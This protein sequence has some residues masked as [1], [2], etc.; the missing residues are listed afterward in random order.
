MGYTGFPA[1]GRMLDLPLL[2]GGQ[3]I[4]TLGPSIVVTPKLAEINLGGRVISA[5]LHESLR[6]SDYIIL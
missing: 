5:L 6:G 3:R 2:A 1:N 4:V